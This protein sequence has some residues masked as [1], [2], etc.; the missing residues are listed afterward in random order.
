[1]YFN[2]LPKILYNFSVLDEERMFIVRDITVNVR[3]LKAA[4]ENITF[5]DEY[6]I[7]DGETPEIISMKMYGTPFYNWAIMLANEK[8]D[9]AIDFPLTYDR[10]EKYVIGTYGAENIYAIH[11]YENASGYIVNSDHEFAVSVSN[12]AYEDKLNEIKRRIKIISK[13]NLQQLLKEFSGI[14]K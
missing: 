5:Y 14:I 8:F 3:I 11:H 10:L 1:M 13:T 6:D 2:T 7:V 9:Y 4:L 12:L